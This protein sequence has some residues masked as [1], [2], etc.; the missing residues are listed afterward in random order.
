MVLK[1]LLICK[2]RKE[3]KSK[4]ESNNNPILHRDIKAVGINS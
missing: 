1:P 3:K 4:S 2:L